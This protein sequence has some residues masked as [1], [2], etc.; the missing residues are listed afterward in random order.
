MTHL[1][2]N[3]NYYQALVQAKNKPRHH[4]DILDST[5]AILFFG[6]PHA[7]LQIDQLVEMVHDMAEVGE[8][9]SRLKLL[10]HLSGG[11]EFLL[12]LRDELTDIW[13]KLNI[14]S[15]YENRKTPTVRKDVR[16]GLV[17]VKT[18]PDP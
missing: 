12:G 3:K 17:A 10:Y 18:V 15:F 7:G 14:Y 4:K 13:D 9:S 8:P 11:S 2:A 5:K 6:T 16:C 1:T